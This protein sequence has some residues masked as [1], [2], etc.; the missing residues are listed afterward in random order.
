MGNHDPCPAMRCQVFNLNQFLSMTKKLTFETKKQGNKLEICSKFHL[1]FKFYKGVTFKALASTWRD[2]L[3]GT[4]RQLPGIRLEGRRRQTSGRGN[5]YFHF[6][7]SLR[8]L[9]LPDIRGEGD[10]TITPLPRAFI[11]LD[12][13][14][15]DHRQDRYLVMRAI[16]SEDLTEIRIGLINY[17]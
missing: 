4:G 7:R 17:S 13:G 8:L 5:I 9:P 14:L 15:M 16:P 3:I 12:M 11:V 6:L 2:E 10:L 1:F